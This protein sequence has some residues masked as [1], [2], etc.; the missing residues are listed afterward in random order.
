MHLPRIGLLALY[1]LA[2]VQF[3]GSLFYLEWP[4]LSIRAW[5]RGHAPLPFQTRILLAPLYRYWD[6]APWSLRYTAKLAHNHY[7]FPRGIYPAMV[8]EFFLGIPCVLLAGWVAVRIYDAGSRRHLLKP[9]VFPLFLGLCTL[10]YIVHTVQNFSFVYDLPSLAAFSVGLYLI[11]FRKPLV[12]FLLLFAVATI[13]RETTLLLLPFWAFSQVIDGQGRRNWRALVRPRVLLTVG[14]LVLYWTVWHWYIFGAFAHN[15]SEYYSR[16][17]Y[18]VHC[19]SKLRYWPQL[20]SAFGYLWPFLILY[21]KRLAD[22]QLRLWLLTLP[23]WYAFMF[24]WAI[25]TETRVFGELLPYVAP[26]CVIMGEE[27]F[28]A[29]VLAGVRR[30]DAETAPLPHRGRA[31]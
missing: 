4:Y 27:V 24:H 16:F 8:L 22:P 20:A 11:Y 9:L 13:N 14:G 10:A 2:T 7:F 6:S 23:I 12:W 21:R 28:A 5:E 18:N 17:W 19:F 30:V 3:V 1:V 25:L 15:S 29:R 26:V 31:A